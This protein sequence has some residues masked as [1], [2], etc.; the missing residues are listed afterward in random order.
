M[1]WTQKLWGI[2]GAIAMTCLAL[3]G[4]AGWIT[5]RRRAK[6]LGQSAVD[7]AKEN[8]ARAKAQA[9]SSAA[10]VDAK[11]KGAQDAAANA[12]ASGLAERISG[13]R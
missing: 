6:A 10:A 12:G 5:E 9:D 13:R 11:A 8:E 3:V 4:M 2:L 1:T 7:L